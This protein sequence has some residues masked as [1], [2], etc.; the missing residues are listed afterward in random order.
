MLCLR[1]AVVIFMNHAT[2]GEVDDPGSR[3]SLDLASA[4]E[5]RVMEPWE[6]T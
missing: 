2:N 1:C 4:L 5:A 6:F 3:E